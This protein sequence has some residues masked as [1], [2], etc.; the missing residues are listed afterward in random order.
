MNFQEIAILLV[1]AGFFGIIAKLIKQPILI[2]YLFAGFFLAAMGFVGDS[3]YL[4]NLG[5]IGVTLL[6]F[7][8]GMEIKIHDLFQFGK[9]TFISAIAQIVVTSFLA[10]F[11]S[12]LM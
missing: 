10:F 9:V 8:L 7:L 2:G 3:T 12:L 5:K 11:V 6:L 4:Q 1:A